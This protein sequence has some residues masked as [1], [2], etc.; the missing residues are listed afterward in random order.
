[1]T[2]EKIIK[3]TYTAQSEGEREIENESTY[4]TTETAR[5]VKYNIQISKHIEVNRAKVRRQNV[6]SIQC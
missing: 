4:S 3:I 6:Y 5:I 2:T 1:M